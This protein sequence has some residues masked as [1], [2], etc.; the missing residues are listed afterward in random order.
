[1]PAADMDEPHFGDLRRDRL[2]H[3]R[4]SIATIE[5]AHDT[6]A[7]GEDTPVLAVGVPSLDTMLGGGLLCG[8]LHELHPARPLDLGAA[9]GFALMVSALAGA[10]GRPVLWIQPDFA[11]SE[12][13]DL[14]GAGLDLLGLPMR[15]LVLARVARSGEALW[16]MEE[17]LKCRALA[18]VVAEFHDDAAA[19]LTVTR[20]LA[21]A[22]RDGGGLGLLFGHRAPDGASAAMT[23][24]EVAASPG[25][26]DRF[27]G[28]GATGLALSL[29]KNRRGPCGRWQL[30]WDHHA[31]HFV[32]P[33]LS[34]GLA[35]TAGD[36]PDR[37]PLAR[38]G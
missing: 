38:A 30:D 17:A 25:T 8:A 15:Q 28:L 37:A 34:V 11:G 18:A 19:D 24:W 32:S 33:A 1:M 21:L 12:S 27:G 35:A 2:Q 5:A 13:G 7:N 20:R 10:Q 14:Y 31:R 29:I 6:R 36:R 4:R 23:R 3:L 9:C 22:A 16:A 26:P